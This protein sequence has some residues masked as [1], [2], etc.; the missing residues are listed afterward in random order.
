MIKHFCDRC[1]KAI[2]LAYDLDP[3]NIALCEDAF[4]DNIDLCP[5]CMREFA[6]WWKGM[7][8]PWKGTKQC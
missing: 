2:G 1:G 5:N 3:S 4:K 7:M 6:E 8:D